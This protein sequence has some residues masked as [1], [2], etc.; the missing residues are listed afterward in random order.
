M[1]RPESMFDTMKPAEPSDAVAKPHA[2]S[3]AVAAASLRALGATQEEAAKGAGVSVRTIRLWESCSWWARATAEAIDENCA[4]IKAFAMRAL[5]E[6][7][8]KGDDV[9]AA[10]WALERLDPKRF[11]AKVD[12]TSGGERLAVTVVVPQPVRR[13]Q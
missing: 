4:L 11:G 6:A 3:K 2:W 9:R 5:L 12:V 13:G 1:N 7:V 10:T 8:R